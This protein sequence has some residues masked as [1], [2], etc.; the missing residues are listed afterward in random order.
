MDLE[1]SNTSSENED[2]IKIQEESPSMLQKQKLDKFLIHYSNHYDM[3]NSYKR[4]FRKDDFEG[5]VEDIFDKALYEFPIF[6]LNE[7]YLKAIGNILAIKIKRIY[8]LKSQTM[9]LVDNFMIQ[10]E[11]QQIR[12]VHDIRTLLRSGIDEE[13]EENTLARPIPTAMNRSTNL[14]TEGQKEQ[15]K[16]KLHKHTSGGYRTNLEKFKEVYYLPTPNTKEI[17]VGNTLLQNQ[18]NITKRLK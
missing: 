13:E 6:G 16:E 2:R 10:R 3:E 14:L 8:N 9:E 7:T 4:F 11:Q 17:S 1:D 18:R 12:N 15:I 5:E